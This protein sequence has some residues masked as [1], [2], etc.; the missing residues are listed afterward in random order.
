M[1]SLAYNFVKMQWQRGKL[2]ADDIAVLVTKGFIT[3]AEADEIMQLPPSQKET[4]AT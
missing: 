1:A 2:T 4:Y 3:Q